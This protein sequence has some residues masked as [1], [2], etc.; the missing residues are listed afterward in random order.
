MHST[1]QDCEYLVKLDTHVE[2]EH[3]TY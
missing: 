3:F 1:S 2:R